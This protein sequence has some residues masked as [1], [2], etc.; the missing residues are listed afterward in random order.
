LERRCLKWAWMTHLDI[1]H[2]SYGQKKG[3][4]SN[5]QFDYQ[6]LKVKNCP[7]FVCR[8]CTT[9]RW[10]DLNE[11]YNFASNLILIR[12]LQTKLWAPKVIGVSILGISRFPFRNPGTKYHL[13]ASSMARHR[14]HYKGE[15]GGFPQGQ[16]MVKLVSPKSLVIHP[17]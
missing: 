9:Y 5:W 7:N 4:E 6:P 11:E 8:W 2:I 14:V 12:G 17:N 1:K 15:G 10:K 3:W 16:V 13:G